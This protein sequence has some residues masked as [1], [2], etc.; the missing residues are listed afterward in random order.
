MNNKRLLHKSPLNRTKSRRMKLIRNS[1]IESLEKRQLLTATPGPFNG[2]PDQNTVIDQYVGF[3]YPGRPY[4]EAELNQWKSTDPVIGPIANVWIESSVDAVEGNDITFNIRRAGTSGA[5]DVTYTIDASS[6]VL[7]GTDFVDWE[8]IVRFEIGS[9]I[10]RINISTINDLQLEADERLA[11]RLVQSSSSTY[12]VDKNIVAA[13]LVDNDSQTALPV[14]GIQPEFVSSFNNERWVKLSRSSGDLSRPLKIT[15]ELN[16][17]GNDLEIDGI[18]FKRKQV[19]T[20]QVVF[21]AHQDSVFIRVNRRGGEASLLIKVLPSNSYTLDSVAEKEIAF[22]VPVEPNLVNS[23]GARLV[24]SIE[25]QKQVVFSFPRQSQ[26]VTLNIDYHNQ[27]QPDRTI[28]I[29]AG[30]TELSIPVLPISSSNGLD[31]FSLKFAVGNGNDL[32]WREFSADSPTPKSK[33][34]TSVAWIGLLVD[35]GANDDNISQNP[36][37]TGGVTGSIVNANRIYFDHDQDG[38][39]D[40]ELKLDKRVFHYDPRSSDENFL[41]GQKSIQYRIGE[42]G[43]WDSFEFQF[44]QPQMS[45]LSVDH[46]SISDDKNGQV[47]TGKLR[48]PTTYTNGEQPP[49]RIPTGINGGYVTAFSQDSD[50]GGLLIEVTTAEIATEGWLNATAGLVSVEVDL[51][52][53]LISDQTLP[54]GTDLAFSVPTLGLAAGDHRLAFRPSEWNVEAA[55]RL[56]G[57]WREIN[58]TVESPFPQFGEVASQVGSLSGVLFESSYGI[59]DVRIDLDANQDGIPDSYALANGRG[60][61]ELAVPSTSVSTVRIRTSLLNSVAGDVR[62]S[63][64]VDVPWQFNASVNPFVDSISVINLDSNGFVVGPKAD[65]IGQLDGAQLS[66]NYSDYSIEFDTNGDG[67]VDQVAFPQADGQFSQSFLDMVS[68][69]SSVGYRVR[70]WDLQ[71]G[72]EYY[73]SWNT[74]Q[75][76]VPEPI[77]LPQQSQSDPT[78]EPGDANGLLKFPV[79]LVGERIPAYSSIEIDFDMDEAEDQTVTVSLGEFAIVKSTIPSGTTIIKVRGVAYAGYSSGGD[80]DGYGGDGYGGD[81][82][83]PIYGPWVEIDLSEYS[84]EFPV[85]VSQLILWSDSGISHSDGKSE[86]TTI[87]GLLFAED[88]AL[89]SQM[90]VQVDENGDGVVDG[91]TTADAQG[92][93]VYR[94]NFLPF[95]EVTVRF[96]PVEWNSSNAGYDVGPWSS[97][98]FTHEDQIDQAAK[99]RTATLSELVA[100]GASETQFTTTL[101][102]RVTNEAGLAG[103]VIEI[104]TNADDEKDQITTTDALGRFRASVFGA[105]TA[106]TSIRIRTRELD[107]ITRQVDYGPW[108]TPS[109]VNGGGDPYGGDSLGGDSSSG[110]GSNES[111]NNSQSAIDEADSQ[112]ESAVAG[113]KSQYDADLVAADDLYTAAI[114]AA[115]IAYQSA[116]A[117]FSGNTTSFD[118]RQMQWPEAPSSTDVTLPD[119]A[120][121]PTPPAQKPTYTGENY[122]FDSD[123]AYQSSLAANRNTYNLELSAARSALVAAKSSAKSRHEA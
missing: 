62:S 117:N 112:H 65:V 9:E 82:S 93:F 100:V 87:A 20:K 26:V 88:P 91:A 30:T 123:A 31:R 98:S 34:P 45:R 50:S 78:G 74:V 64:W 44:Q 13:S 110:G 16:A 33:G 94:P 108:T 12:Q 107:P 77:E 85:L 14:V 24:G 56:N 71:T 109:Q 4:T 106:L 15:V 23:F 48:L 104:D 18:N 95:G 6:T 111:D 10:A 83:D 102:G 32:V 59:N 121:M 47:I 22:L 80:G 40:G 39:A 81:G 67:R 41:P 57:L 96:R 46:L 25:E 92:G 2:L 75:L 101:S 84:S 17:Q 105:S 35:T 27:E 5:L 116:L 97:L 122:A 115:G 21:P 53:D 51:D 70:G 68:G 90:I 29:A 118:Y 1:I 52:G 49:P 58:V 73:G 63:D 54:L 43:P 66:G 72:A 36:T 55:A 99:I 113:A 60:L 86:N 42:N 103:I 28:T 114:E 89:V 69:V 120:S 119:D 3:G 76:K 8:G 38:F 19:K 61:F 11:L 79:A 7:P 37:L